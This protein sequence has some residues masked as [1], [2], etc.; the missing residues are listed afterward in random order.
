MTADIFQF[1]LN[2]GWA[3]FLVF[4]GLWYISAVRSAAQ[5][6]DTLS[7]TIACIF[8]TGIVSFGFGAIFTAQKVG[9]AA[10]VLVQW[11]GGKD[12][13]IG[14]V[15]TARM[16]QYK[17]KYK[18]V[19]I[20]GPVDSQRDQQTDTRIVVSNPFTITG[21]PILIVSPYGDEMKA[22]VV[23]FPQQWTR[24]ALIPSGVEPNKI[25]SLTGL[26]AIGGIVFKP[27]DAGDVQ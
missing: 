19:V 23:N 18:L 12:R 4:C 25:T 3:I 20:C 1:F 24:A 2:Y 14:V 5:P 13:C 16:I 17:E 9:V 22:N 15:N 10:D 11:G 21:G 6:V 8:M 27:K 26:Q 7:V